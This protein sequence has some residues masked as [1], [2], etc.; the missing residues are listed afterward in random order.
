MLVIPDRDDA[1]MARITNMAIEKS[2][3]K[4]L[5]ALGNEAELAFRSKRGVP[6]PG[7]CDVAAKEKGI[8]FSAPTA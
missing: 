7:R 5:W 4:L 2:C 1:G 6:N 8:A 3:R